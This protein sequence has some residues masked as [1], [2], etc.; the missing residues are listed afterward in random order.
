MVHD[1]EMFGRVVLGEWVGKVCDAWAKINQELLLMDTVLY[2]M[3]TLIHGFGLLGID[4]IIGVTVRC[5]VVDLQRSW[6]LWMTQFFQGCHSWERLRYV[7]IGGSN[8]R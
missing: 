4:G 2:P 1:A 3:V 8:F 7:M 6:G 5:C